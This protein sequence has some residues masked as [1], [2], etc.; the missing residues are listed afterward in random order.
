MPPRVVVLYDEPDFAGQLA[1]ALRLAGYSVDA[2]IG[3]VAEWQV[4]ARLQQADVLITGVE[5]P[6]GRSNGVIVALRVGNH[7]DIHLL[8]AGE[9]KGAERADRAGAVLRV[10]QGTVTNVVKTVK[11]LLESGAERPHRPAEIGGSRNDHLAKPVIP[12]LEPEVERILSRRCAT[13]R[14]WEKRRRGVVKV[15]ADRT[16]T[17]RR[18]SIDPGLTTF[19]DDGCS[20][21]RRS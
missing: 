1:S 4:I 14:F 2:F 16:A 20:N 12:Q 5:Y 8:V 7:P 18:C 3:P 21:W 19:P 17:A 15:Q 11:L 10:A 6:P 13:C 9:P